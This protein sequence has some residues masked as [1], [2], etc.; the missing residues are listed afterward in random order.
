KGRR[1]YKKLH[2][3]L[4]E[5]LMHLNVLYYAA[6]TLYNFKN[7]ATKQTAIA[8]TSTAITF[9]LLIGV[10]VH[11]AFKLFKRRKS[12]RKFSSKTLPTVTVAPTNQVYL[13]CNN[14]QHKQVTFSVMEISESPS[15][16]PENALHELTQTPDHA[17]SSTDKQN[18]TNKC[19]D[20]Y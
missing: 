20:T 19:Q 18:N 6:F 3:E 2:A 11:N 13:N 9:I 7:D 14:P 17:K 12:Q 15:N 10:I 4:I 1:V 16:S 8:Y 5:T